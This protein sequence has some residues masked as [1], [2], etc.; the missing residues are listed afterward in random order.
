MPTPPC[1]TRSRRR[2]GSRRRPLA[3]AVR[4]ART[5]A[6]RQLH[7]CQLTEGLRPRR[8]SR[9]P[10]RRLP[11]PLARLPPRRTVRGARS[12]SSGGKVR[13]HARRVLALLVSLGH[14][15]R[16]LRPAA[17][18]R[19]GASPA[20]TARSSHAAERGLC[21]RLCGA[22]ARLPPTVAG[23]LAAAAARLPFARRLARVSH[24]TLHR[25]GGGAP[26]FARP[27]RPPCH[28]IFRRSEKK[29]GNSRG[30]GKQTTTKNKTDN[31]SHAHPEWC[32]G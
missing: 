2:P 3:S 23:A 7:P 25:L 21:L 24:R 8:S 1:K 20:A 12:S 11:P 28:G 4:K 5:H 30:H 13:R 26:R 10:P 6:A 18:A 19:R 31:S 9:L 14:A 22:V 27:S 29:T 32:Q 15:A 17:R 16:P